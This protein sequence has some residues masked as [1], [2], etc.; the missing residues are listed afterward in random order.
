VRSSVY[1]LAGTAFAILA[2]LGAGPCKEGKPPE[3][4]CKACEANPSLPGCAV[5]LAACKGTPTTTTTTTTSSTTTQPPAPPSPVPACTIVWTNGTCKAAAEEL[6]VGEWR[7][8]LRK[9]KADRPDLFRPD[10][11]RPPGE[12]LIVTDVNGFFAAAVKAA[13]DLHLCAGTDN[14]QVWLRPGPSGDIDSW[15]PVAQPAGGTDAYLVE[16]PF[17]LKGPCTP[18]GTGPPPVNPP[19][20]PSSTPGPTPSPAPSP[21]VACQSPTPGPLASMEVKVHVR[22]PNW[23]T[24][25]ATPKVGAREGTGCVRDK[26]YCAAIGFTDGRGFCPPRQ[27]GN[28]QRIACD[29]EVTGG[30][31]AWTWNG[32]P[33][34]KEGEPGHVD[35]PEAMLHEGGWMLLVKAGR[36][37]QARACPKVSAHCPD[38]CGQVEL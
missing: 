23:T 9:V 12:R 16:Y 36:H 21:G 29:R 13:Q 38:E 6:Y 30:G 14:I 11:S 34:T 24:V 1:P 7:D 19:P 37:G 17:G 15:D 4:I 20:T 8:T 18:A 28:P 27:E 31:I 22:G 5:A 25:D 32:S 33:I 35:N 26:A 2:A 10:P 3:E